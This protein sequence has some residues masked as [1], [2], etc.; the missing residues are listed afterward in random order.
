MRKVFKVFGITALFTALPV[1]FTGG[2]SGDSLV[3]MNN[4]CAE[5]DDGGKCKPRPG[6]ICFAMDPDGEPHLFERA[7]QQ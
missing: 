3:R 1:A 5:G 7:S 6:S 4:V 2:A